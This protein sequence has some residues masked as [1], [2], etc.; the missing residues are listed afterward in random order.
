M[1]CYI[2]KYER[3]AL[4]KLRCGILP[5]KIETGR[6]NHI[7][8]E[9]RICELCNLNEI[10]NERHFGCRCTLYNDY[11]QQLYNSVFTIYPDFVALS[12]EEKFIYLMTHQQIKLAKYTWKAFQ[13]RTN[14]MYS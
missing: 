3:S 10:E 9:F 8:E 14:I 7:P 11:R 6:Y 4:A 5:I 12:N 2:P 13:K 1:S